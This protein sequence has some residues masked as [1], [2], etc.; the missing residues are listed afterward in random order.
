MSE[1]NGNEAWGTHGITVLEDPI[2]EFNARNGFVLDE[3]LA[4]ADAAD[5]SYKKSVAEG[6]D[7]W[8]AIQAGLPS[9]EFFEDPQTGQKLRVRRFNW[10]ADGD[11]SERTVGAIFS[12]FSVTISLDHIEYQNSLTAKA[13]GPTDPP[14][15]LWSYL[16]EEVGG[17]PLLVIENPGYGKSD[18]L[19]DTQKAELRLFGGFHSVA[20]SMLGVM[21]SLGVKKV[22][23]S[24]YSMGADIAAAVAARAKT[25]EKDYGIEVENL[26]VMES[27]R[28][29]VQPPLTLV[30]NF[31]GEGKN[32]K[33]AWKKT[34]DPVLKKVAKVG[35]N[36]PLKGATTYG[37]ALYRGGLNQDLLAALSN[38]P[39]I[40]LTI[41]SSGASKISASETNPHAS[42]ALYQ[43][44][45][46]H[47]PEP[48][49][50]RQIV[51]PGESHAFGDNAQRNVA[52]N[53]FVLTGSFGLVSSEHFS[54]T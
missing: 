49:R 54:S 31:M 25:K 10:P 17:S 37:R 33:F 26:F 51:M 43:W 20:E 22:N 13:M 34:G 23:L 50:V 18:K 14:K 6:D 48:H 11:V 39:N 38:Q 35:L 27:P 24:G 19:T 46:M 30:K 4:A 7:P 21:S 53:R 28:T 40:R 29:T 16:P 8:E 47:F 42:A 36:S 5:V 3:Y 1:F 32:L 15:E 9:F 44:L 12:Q 52:L 45:K 2:G 41:G